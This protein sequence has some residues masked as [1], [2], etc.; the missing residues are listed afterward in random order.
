MGALFDSVKQI[1]TVVKEGGVKDLPIRDYRLKFEL[2]NYLK[3][4]GERPETSASSVAKVLRSYS[5]TP[6][7]ALEYAISQLALLNRHKVSTWRRMRLLE[8]YLRYLAPHIA[9]VYLNCRD[10][11]AVPESSARRENLDRVGE[12]LRE[13]SAGYERIFDHDYRLSDLRYVINRPRLRQAGHRLLDL[14]LTEQRVNALRYQLLSPKR[15]AV[16]NQVFFILWHYEDATQAVRL[17]GCIPTYLRDNRSVIETGAI[18]ASAQQLY[19]SIQLL[20]MVDTL[21]WPAEQIHVMDAY[22]KIIEPKVKIREDAGGEVPSGHLLCLFGQDRPAV[23]ARKDKYTTGLLLDISA[24]K[25]QVNDDHAII[26]S[27]PPEAAVEKMSPP[28]SVLGA[29]D[30]GLFLERL[31][32]RLHPRLRRHERQ[33]INQYE[34]MK[35]FFGFT[36]AHRRLH[37][38][39]HPKTKTK[40]TN[41]L[42]EMLAGRTSMLTD[43]SRQIKDEAR[44]FVV[45]D[46]EGGTQIKTRETTYVTPMAIGQVAL[47]NAIDGAETDFIIGYIGRITRAS[48]DLLITLIKLADEVRAIAVQTPSEQKAEQAWPAFLIRNRNARWQIVAHNKNRLSSG[49][50]VFLRQEKKTISVILGETAS[51]HEEFT[52]FSVQPENPAE[53]I[54]L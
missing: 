41:T 29:Q 33:H 2:P 8:T 37:N 18:K 6:L 24:L 31:R 25:T 53:E 5:A 23:Y 51:R 32:L 22:M 11:H 4:R 28:L 21:T 45:N 10:S 52:I 1:W 42:S 48:G 17:S 36:E 16:C 39:Q 9:N 7:V 47:F 46:S 49:A 27:L 54:A 12:A 3:G 26:F 50:N 30:R 44:W 20:G 14:I 15:W 13:L 40:D 34:N 38:I 19:I 43:D 35:A